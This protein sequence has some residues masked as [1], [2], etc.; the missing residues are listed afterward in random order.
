[1]YSSAVWPISLW[2]GGSL[3]RGNQTSFCTSTDKRKSAVSCSNCNDCV[4]TAVQ[5]CFC[6]QPCPFFRSCL[7]LYDF[8]AYSG[9]L[10]SCSRVLVLVIQQ[11]FLFWRYSS[12]GIHLKRTRGSSAFVFLRGSLYMSSH[13]F[14]KIKNRCLRDSE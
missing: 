13:I 9:P 1:M 8:F 5:H 7:I 14:A 4:C 11:H 3:S 12:C 6:P 2:P 10:M